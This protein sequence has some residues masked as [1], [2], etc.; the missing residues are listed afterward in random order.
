MCVHKRCIWIWFCHIVYS[1]GGDFD[2]KGKKNPKQT[3][4]NPHSFTTLI[5][6]ITLRWS[7]N[8]LYYSGLLGCFYK[9]KKVEPG[10]TN[11]SVKCFLVL[12]A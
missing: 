4:R 8:T 3:K 1:I 10:K 6:Y 2:F 12:T 9:K 7:Q 5:H 11:K